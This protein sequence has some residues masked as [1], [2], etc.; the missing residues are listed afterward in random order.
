MTG[1]IVYK[2][3][4]YIFDYEKNMISIYTKDI[5]ELYNNWLGKFTEKNESIIYILKGYQFPNLNP[6]E[7]IFLSGIDQ[8]LGKHKVDMKIE[9]YSKK[10]LEYNQV[11]FTSNVIDAIYG[12]EHYINSRKRNEDGRQKIELKPYNESDSKIYNFKFEDLDVQMQFQTK[13]IFTRNTNSMLSRKTYIDFKLSDNLNYQK[14]Y[15]LINLIYNFLSFIIYNKNVK[16]ETIELY[17]EREN[18]GSA[19]FYRDNLLEEVKIENINR[20]LK[21]EYIENS[22]EGLLE[23]LANNE[24]YLRNIPQSNRYIDGKEILMTTAGFEYVFEKVFKKVEHGIETLN[25]REDLIKKLEDVKESVVDCKEK[26]MIDNIINGINK[27]DIKSKIIATNKKMNN[28]PEKILMKL[29]TINGRK[30]KFNNV[31]EQIRVVRNY[32]AHGKLNMDIQEKNENAILGIIMLD[33]IIYLLQL[34]E[35]GI[36]DE[37]IYKEILANMFNIF[38]S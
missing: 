29:L 26:K 4:E 33:K 15:K 38:I 23:K 18:I 36:T 2:D 9:Y 28:I 8:L 19:E 21:L 7:F 3:V 10:I 32:Y 27:D 13:R 37:K 5:T 11:K 24:I 12:T 6:V 22:I 14:L 1:Y 16:F 35:I 25:R 20:Y 30:D 17:N 34:R 31:C